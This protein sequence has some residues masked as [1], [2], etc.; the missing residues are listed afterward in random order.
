MNIP[1]VAKRIA[2]TY[3]GRSEYVQIRFGTRLEKIIIEE[4]RAAVRRDDPE[5]EWL[6]RRLDK[7][8]ENTKTQKGEK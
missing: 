8:S 2:D 7:I 4:L 6:R 3:F 5:E 1:D